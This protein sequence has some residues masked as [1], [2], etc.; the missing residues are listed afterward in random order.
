MPDAHRRLSSRPRRSEA[1]RRLR[2]RHRNRHR[3]SGARELW[4]RRSVRDAE[5]RAG[6]SKAE[7]RPA[8][9][10]D[11]GSMR[12]TT[13]L[14]RLGFRGSRVQIP[15]S[16]LSE[17]QALQRLS[18]WG[19]FFAC[20]PC[21]EFCCEWRGSSRGSA[22]P[23]KRVLHGPHS[24]LRNSSTVSPAS[25][26]MPPIVYAFTG[27]CRGI[28]R[29]RTPSVITMCFPCRTT[30]NPAFSSARTASRWLTLGTFGTLS[31]RRRLRGPPCRV[32][33]LRGRR[34]TRRWHPGWF[35][36]PHLPSLPETSSRG[37]PELK[38]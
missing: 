1:R 13:Q 35:P 31:P 17:E 38:R 2:N 6:V 29:M 32:V 18:L 26:T 15:P 22:L 23:L 8:V 12:Q 20:A 37:A 7:C 21:C 5:R 10:K 25:R 34:G 16:R 14:Q 9:S 27:L 3:A 36:T 4:R 28:V 33:D 24:N 30:P 11:G 19:F